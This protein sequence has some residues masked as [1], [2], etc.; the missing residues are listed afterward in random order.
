MDKIKKNLHII[1]PL[2]IVLIMIFYVI[3]YEV[4]YALSRRLPASGYDLT[5]S[6]LTEYA[7]DKDVTQMDSPGDLVEAVQTAFYE[8]SDFSYVIELNDHNTRAIAY[9][10][11][12]KSE[13][14]G[15]LESPYYP[16][17]P[18]DT[19]ESAVLYVSGG[20]RYGEMWRL[21]VMAVDYGD[22][23]TADRLF[24]D[25]RIRMGKEA[26]DKYFR[27]DDCLISSDWYRVYGIYRS[28]TTIYYIGARSNAIGLDDTLNY[29]DMTDICNYLGI[30]VPSE[31]VRVDEVYY[32][33]YYRNEVYNRDQY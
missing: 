2:F 23:K 4:A 19:I 28:G 5:V 8:R 22:T 12:D 29:D 7:Q 31:M 10:L 24:V 26:N 30:P 3:A 6:Q 27:T 32:Q 20:G 18:D 15:W 1:L 11:F 13:D 17:K 21:S 25:M 16:C 9:E 14:H 33:E